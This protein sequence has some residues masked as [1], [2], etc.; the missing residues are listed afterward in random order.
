MTY[1]DSILE[2]VNL[3]SLG[4]VTCTLL[5]EKGICKS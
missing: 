5:M 1:N 3:K 4:M 2:Y